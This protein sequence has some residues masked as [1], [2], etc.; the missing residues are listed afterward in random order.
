[1][2]DS[3]T[4]KETWLLTRQLHYTATRNSELAGF[5][6]YKSPADVN[7]NMIRYPNHKLETTSHMQRGV[8]CEEPIL[9]EFAARY[10]MTLDLSPLIVSG[11]DV[12]EAATA[13]TSICDGAR[14]QP[15]F[16]DGGWNLWAPG[17]FRADGLATGEAK[18][19]S[20]DMCSPPSHYMIQ[21]IKQVN[22]WRRPGGY[23]MS[24]EVPAGRR[25]AWYITY[26][27]AF[28]RSVMRR[29]RRSARYIDARLPQGKH[30]C[31]WRIKHMEKLIAA[32]FRYSL[33]KNVEC[34]KQPFLKPLKPTQLPL[35]I[36]IQ[37]KGHYQDK[38]VEPRPQ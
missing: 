10:G 33:Y 22:I 8:D 12:R 32:K 20:W 13:D 9:E 7:L 37:L 18:C 35:P 19:P 3:T 11:L 6:K 21:T 29:S 4:E 16:H 26:D 28:Y 1:M 31:E 2:T 15:L 30:V 5:S 14:D 38:P 34:R 23:L 36:P 17:T 24:S 27:H 25:N